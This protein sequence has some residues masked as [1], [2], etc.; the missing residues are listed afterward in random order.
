MHRA[1]FLRRWATPLSPVLSFVAPAARF[2]ALWRAVVAVVLACCCVAPAFALRVGFV[3][4][5]RHDEAYWVL[6]TQAMQR[7]AQS[8]GIELEV[9]YAERD[10]LR[11][12][13]IA[14][15][16]ASRP[17]ATR[18]QYLVL[19]NERRMG[20]AMLKMASAA[21]IRCIFAYNTLL[22]EE[23][24]EYGA[25]RERYP[26][27]LGSIVPHA[28]DAGYLT[29]NALIARGLR[30]HRFGAD[31]K[32]HLIALAGDRSTESSV[33]RNEGMAQAVREHPEVVLDQMVYADWQ[34]AKAQ[35]MARELY[36]RYPQAALV[37]AGNDLMA[38]GAMDALQAI[39]GKPG[40]DRYFSGVNTSPEAMQAVIDGRMEALA[41]GH[42]MAGAWALV[43][44][45]D[46]AH[47][48]DFASE[49]LELDRP[50]F[51][52]FDRA[53]A[54]RYL[55]RCADGVPPLDFRSRSKALNPARR[56][57]DFDFATLLP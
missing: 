7:A 41:G 3:N 24:A 6:A 9:R 39:G 15:E 26:L 12:L 34:R 56:R 19:V 22:P 49:G 23:R 30:E 11:Q 44:I 37:W 55:A 51:V 14:R 36:A 53:L 1:S 45:Y 48:H 29:A 20:G 25:P 47:G 54:R 21:G 46:H 5:G 27:W 57:Y 32:L 42:F 35:T 28:Q 4:P 50:M 13:D 38:F 31:G 8:L 33:L 2:G 17:P 52:L 40:V 16:F 10:H 43:M 18:P